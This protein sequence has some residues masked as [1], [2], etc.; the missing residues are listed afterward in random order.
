MRCRSGRQTRLSG[1][2]SYGLMEILLHPYLPSKINRLRLPARETPNRMHSL[3][4]L[5][6]RGRVLR[7]LCGPVL[8]AAALAATGCGDDPITNPDTPTPTAITET[9]EGTVTINGAITQPFV[10]QTAGTVVAAFTALEP[11]EA[12]LGLSIGTWNGVTCAIVLA[13]DDA[14]AGA[15]V[16]G[17]ATATGN[18]CVRVY[19]VGRLT[20]A[21]SYQ[22]TVTHF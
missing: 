17:S 1:R 16:T 11:T 12:R 18:Y 7:G 21:V 10:V 8:V 3:F 6:P 13:N 14:T 5:R 19:D 15:S 4:H 22:L 9:F 20:Q 2:A